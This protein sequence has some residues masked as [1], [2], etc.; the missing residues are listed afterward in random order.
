M[1]RRK[2]KDAKV[3]V[4]PPPDKNPDNRF[5]QIAALGLKRLEERLVSGEATGAEIVYAIQFADPLRP[6][7]KAKLARENELLKSK[8]EAIDSAQKTEELY[9]NAIAAMRSYHGVDEGGPDISRLDA[10]F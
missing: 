3:L 6:L 8:K 10:D 7:K 5:Q 1:P 4:A 2:V 9:A